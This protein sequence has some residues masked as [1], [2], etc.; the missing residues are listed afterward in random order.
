MT[1]TVTLPKPI[2]TNKLFANIRGKGRVK[3]KR[4]MTWRNAAQWMF[5]ADK[6]K[7]ILGPVEVDIFIPDSFRGDIDNSLKCL[8]DSLVEYGCI[9][10]D[11]HIVSLAVKRYSGKDTLITYSAYKMARAA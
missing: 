7:R 5:Q 2:S 11:R 3:T 9:E 8:L 4:Y 1:Q 10:D 6:P